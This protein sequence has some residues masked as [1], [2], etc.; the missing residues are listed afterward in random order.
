M[1]LTMWIEVQAGA[2]MEGISSALTAMGTQ[3][4][5]VDSIVSGF[6]DRSNCQFMF[7]Y[8]SSPEEVVL[9][10]L[11]VDWNVGIR[12]S[13]HYRAGNL[14][15]SWMDIVDFVRSYAAS[16]PFK[17]VV[18]FQFATLYAVRDEYGLRIVV[19]LPEG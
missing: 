8:D 7:R 14:H 9:E 5:T 13:F 11:E 18:S 2:S 12:G 16:Q 1:S 19:P 10:S 15:E 17:F 4:E 3:T 6:F